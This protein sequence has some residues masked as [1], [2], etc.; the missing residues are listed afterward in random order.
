VTTYV[1]PADA[2]EGFVFTPNPAECSG[3]EF[4]LG[5]GFEV[6]DNGQFKKNKGSERLRLTRSEPVDGTPDSWVVEFT[7]VDDKVDIDGASPTIVITTFAVCS[8]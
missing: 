7:V 5:G 3:T 1:L 8:N 4:V 6:F 2:P